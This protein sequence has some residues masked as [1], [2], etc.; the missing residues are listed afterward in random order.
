MRK[1][2]IGIVAIAAM[3]GT[4]V[5]AADMAVKAPPSPPAPVFSWT[6]FYVGANG[7]FAWD[8]QTISFAPN[9]PISN[10]LF[11]GILGSTPPGAISP[12]ATSAI[13]GFQG[14]YNWQVNPNWVVGIEADFD[15]SHLKSNGVSNFLMF[16][17]APPGGP[18]NI[19]SSQ[20]VDW[21]GTLRGRLG[22]VV[23]PN[24]LLYATGGAA[25]GHLSEQ[26]NLNAPTGNFG[27]GVTSGFICTANT[28][29]FIGNASQ[30]RWGWTAG[31]GIEFAPWNNG[32]LLRA[33]YLFIGLDS[34]T[35]NLTA[36]N[37]DGSPS[38]SSIAASGRTDIS[39]VRGGV[40][41]KF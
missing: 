35:V 10:A 24:T 21:F 34:G 41:W 32:L 16:P 14:G 22:Y 1:A 25:Y 8:R 33:E 18:A 4:P 28:N 20:N 11:S 17:T 37:S 23:A 6:G 31:G 19:Q 38:P 2:G 15:W 9:D 39:V 26:L 29:C 13:G 36:V 27:S 12:T 40:N 5:L 7:G 30:T 3:I